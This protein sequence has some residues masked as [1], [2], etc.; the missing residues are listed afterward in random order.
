MCALVVFDR[1]M[2]MRRF[3]VDDTRSYED[4]SHQWWSRCVVYEWVCVCVICAFHWD[5][6]GVQITDVLCIVQDLSEEAAT[7]DDWTV[8]SKCETFTPPR[9]HHCRWVSVCQ[10]V[11]PILMIFVGGVSG[12]WTII[13][14]GEEDDQL[15]VVTSL[16]R[17]S[18]YVGEANLKFFIFLCRYVIHWTCLNDC[19]LS[20]SFWLLVFCKETL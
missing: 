10:C 5:V 9:P 2:R 19:V 6:W 13:V 7:I 17:M 15:V 3:G 16:C 20:K 8:S 12:G 1:N 14:H 4:N 11:C 18:N